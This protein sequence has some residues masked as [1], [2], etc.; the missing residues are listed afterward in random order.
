MQVEKL[1]ILLECLL[2]YTQPIVYPK[3]MGIAIQTTV[4]AN[5][6]SSVMTVCNHGF[7]NGAMT[8]MLQAGVSTIHRMFV[9]WVAFMGAIF[10]CLNLKLDDGFL[11]YSMP[12][13]FNKTDY[14]LTDIIV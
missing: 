4:K 1:N 12:D 7:H 6:L 8:Y 11:P 3:Y 13:V 10:S 14:G 9:M 5:E 2:P